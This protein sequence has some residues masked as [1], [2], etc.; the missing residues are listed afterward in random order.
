MSKMITH[1]IPYPVLLHILNSAGV[2]RF[3][4]AQMDMVRLGIGLYGIGSSKEEQTRL[5]NVSTRKSAITQIKR[6][7]AGDTIGYNRQGKAID[8]MV[9][10]VVAIGYAD[11]LNRRLGNGIGA[12]Y[13]HR[14]PAP[15]IGNVCMDL[16]M[17]DITGIEITGIKTCIKEGDEVII[18]GDDHPIG[19][20]AGK[21]GTIPYEVLTSI[22]RRVK[23]IY[24]HE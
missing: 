16:T 24:F 9:V 14:Q 1:N 3:P 13:V 2:S 10:A 21:I 7:Q 5:R 12:L 15:V 4:E 17:I 19:E 8:D 6:I 23:R 20:L 11:G 22:S 18:F